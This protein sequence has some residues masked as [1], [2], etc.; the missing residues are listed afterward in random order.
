MIYRAYN[1]SYSG[2]NSTV[3]YTKCGIMEL[4]RIEKTIYNEIKRYGKIRWGQLRKIIVDEKNIISERPF[5]ET[6]NNMV[7]NGIVFR[8]EIDKQNVEYYVD[9]NIVKLEE[10]SHEFFE[11]ILPEI[12]KLISHIKKNRSKIDSVT[13][14]GYV[15]TLWQVISHFEYKG[16]VLSFLTKTSRVSRREE[17]DDIRVELFKIIFQTKKHE[18]VLEL[19]GLSDSILNVGTRE[20][21]VKIREDLNS[22]NIP[23]EPTQKYYAFINE[24]S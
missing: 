23:W 22:R 19:M 16:E 4:N 13:L 5:R 1:K 11:T 14:A 2:T 24:Q 8:D 15:A 21:F 12:K 9:V 7:G 3:Q 6:L 20:V 18:D 17:C 10:D